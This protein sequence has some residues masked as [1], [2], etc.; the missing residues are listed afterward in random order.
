MGKGFSE[1]Q[2][3][4]IYPPGIENHYW[5]HARNKIIVRILK[6]NRMDKDNLLEIGCGRGVVLGY[7]RKRGFNSIGV[8]LGDSDPFPESREFIFTRTDAFCLSNEIRQVIKGVLLFD[9][10]EHIEDP[11]KF[12]HEIKVKFAEATHVIVTVP[13]RQ[14]LWTNYDEFNGHF[15]RYNLNDF[16]KFIDAGISLKEASYFNH[17]LYPVFWIIAKL[18]RGRGTVIKA[19]SGLMILIHRVLSMVL[20]ADFRFLPGRLLGTSAIAVFS[21][22]NK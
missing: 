5:N 7:L 10:I 17:L 19:P 6:K 21:M 4:A 15:K 8:E 22:N 1:E 13:A 16:E 2:F 11:V 20:Q 12:M 9:V 14:E 3:N 18:K